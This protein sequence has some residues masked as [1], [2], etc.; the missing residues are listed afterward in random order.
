MADSRAAYLADSKEHRWVV[1]L[2]LQSVV[3]TV[4]R[5]VDLRD[6]L[7]AALMAVQTVVRMADQMVGKK[8]HRSAVMKAV[9]SVEK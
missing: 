4:L 7:T 2:A 3:R 9:H 1:P 5:L 8:V 6:I